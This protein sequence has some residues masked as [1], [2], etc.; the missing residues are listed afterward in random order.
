M[1]VSLQGLADAFGVSRTQ[2]E[3]KIS[4]FPFKQ[5]SDKEFD[6]LVEAIPSTIQA[7]IEEGTD[8]GRRSDQFYSVV[9]HLKESGWSPQ[10]IFAHLSTHPGGIA[11]KYL[12]RLELEVN[13]AFG[14]VKASSASEVFGDD[15]QLKSTPSITA[16]LKSKRDLR[17]EYCD[18]ISWNSQSAKYLIKKFIDQHS[19]AL[20]VGASGAGKTFFAITLGFS[21]ATGREFFGMKTAQGP[22][23]Y[24]AGEGVAGIRR[25]IAAIKKEWGLEGQNIPFALMPECLDLCSTKLARLALIESIKTIGQM[26]GAPILIVIDTLSR[27]MAGGDENSPTDMGALVANVGAIVDATGAAVLIIHHFGKDAKAGPRGHSLLI[28]AVDTS[29]EVT[30]KD[31]AAKIS[32]AESAK[33]K[34]YDDVAPLTFKLKSVHLGIDEE[35]DWI[36]S[37]VATPITD[38]EGKAL[39]A[40]ELKGHPKAALDLLTKLVAAE[41]NPNGV[42]MEVWRKAFKESFP[43]DTPEPTARSAFRRSLEVL[44]AS[45][46][47]TE[48]GVHVTLN[49]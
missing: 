19:T 43:P 17:V 9:A 6:A 38:T 14:K 40:G 34:D 16:D 29:I 32:V 8:V 24:I 31:K 46:L 26:I 15:P 28:A 47:V 10:D 22:V 48:R 13:R 1:P 49:A 44:R 3:S 30:M 21:V 18:A 5:A 25:R 37:A 42:S 41:A 2:V 20:L 36:T 35:G 33:L 45:H 27:S 11:E 12:G 4:A 7:I 23:L 39:R